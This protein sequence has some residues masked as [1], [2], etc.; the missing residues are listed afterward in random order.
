[1]L[2][3]NV[4]LQIAEFIK[5]I[6]DHFRDFIA[7]QFNDDAHAIFVRFIAQIGYAGDRLVVDQFGNVFDQ[8]RFIDV[9]GN[10]IDDKAL[11]LGLPSILFDADH[12]RAASFC[13][14]LCDKPL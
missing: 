13:P 3:P 4:H 11:F 6:D 8:A 12:V 7:L 14:Y 9:I 2:Q 10:F 1:M 5:L